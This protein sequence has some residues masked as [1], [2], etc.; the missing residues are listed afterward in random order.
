MR[1]EPEIRILADGAAIAKRAAQEFIQAAAAAVRERGVFHVALAGGSTPKALYGLLANDPAMRS[2]V[3]W[4]KIQVFFGDERH[5]GPGHADSNFRMATE[6]MLSKV[7]LK[8]NQVTRIKGECPDAGQAAHEYEDAI[9]VHFHLKA[10][11][12]PRFD[13]LLV[14][15]GN[16]GHTLSLFPGT[17]ALHADGRIVVSNW[18]GK[19]YT[20]RI[21]LTAPAACAAAEILFMVTGAD[22]ALALKGVLEGPYEPEQMPAQLL[23]PKNGKLLW[24]VDT[25]A[26]GMLSKGIRE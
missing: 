2:Q 5:V 10:G 7:P 6:A 24:L 14:G 21:T 4:D 15:M 18:V 23:Q 11:E 26:G 9:A 13:L 20:D 8:A 19:L 12:F 25:A 3:P 17:K 16:E 1:V 22:K